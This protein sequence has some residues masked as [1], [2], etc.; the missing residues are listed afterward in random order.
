MDLAGAS[1]VKSPTFGERV[2]HASKEGAKAVAADYG[3]VRAAETAAG[4]VAGAVAGAKTVTYVGTRLAVRGGTKVVLK[5][6]LAGSGI[7]S[8]V[9]LANDAVTFGKAFHKAYIS[10]K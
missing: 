2:W 9:T 5:G 4:A 1:A 10:Y 7:L 6:A 8:A 3:L